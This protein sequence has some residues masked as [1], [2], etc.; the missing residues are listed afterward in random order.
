TVA[1]GMLE[2]ARGLGM[3]DG[4][5]G[6]GVDRVIVEQKINRSAADL[7]CAHHDTVGC[8]AHARH[9][10]PRQ[11]A[12]LDET[13]VVD[14]SRDGFARRPAPALALLGDRSRTGRVEDG[15]AGLAHLLEVWTQGFIG[16]CL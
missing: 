14:Q 12:I 1:L 7:R 15:I 5:L 3:V 2:H 11:P 4:T 16:V 6:T 9:G 10:W 8:S 13:A